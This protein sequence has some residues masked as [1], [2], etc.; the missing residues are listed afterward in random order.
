MEHILERI[1][2]KLESVEAQ[3]VQMRED[4][5]WIKGK[6]EG[7]I[8][9]RTTIVAWAGVVFGIAALLLKLFTNFSCSLTSPSL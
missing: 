3:Q 9:T 1:E 5:A 7:R 2:R 4:I 6:L 8:D